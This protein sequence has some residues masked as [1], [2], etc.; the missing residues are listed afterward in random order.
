MAAL[1]DDE[2]LDAFAL[3]GTPEDIPNL[4]ADRYGGLVD[5]LSFNVDVSR[6]ADRWGAVVERIRAIPGR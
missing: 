2:V 5:R 1:I 6:D 4:V 3:V